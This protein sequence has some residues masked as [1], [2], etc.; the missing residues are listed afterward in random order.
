MASK[1]HFYS[2]LPAG[3]FSTSEFSRVCYFSMSCMMHY[4]KRTGI[5][6][7]KIKERLLIFTQPA[8]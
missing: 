4:L 1:A 8:I 5:I 3:F 2:L 6:R 7:F